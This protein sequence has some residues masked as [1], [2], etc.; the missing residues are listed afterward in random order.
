MLAHT[1]TLHTFPIVCLWYLF[2]DSGET[3]KDASIKP[4]DEDDLLVQQE[5]AT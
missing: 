4:G 2:L 1:K 3:V 5:E